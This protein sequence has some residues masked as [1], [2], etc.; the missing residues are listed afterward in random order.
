MEKEKNTECIIKTYK[1]RYL[2][3]NGD[4]REYTRTYKCNGKSV[5]RKK[6]TSTKIMEIIREWP[7]EKQIKLYN[8][9][10]KHEQ[11]RD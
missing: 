10:S 2:L 7:E 3:K 8:K 1:S 5:G 6:K 4:I 11:R 9:L